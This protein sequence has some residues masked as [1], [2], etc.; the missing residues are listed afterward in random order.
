MLSAQIEQK[1]EKKGRNKLLRH[2]FDPLLL[3]CVIYRANAFSYITACRLRPINVGYIY[4]KYLESRITVM[5][6]IE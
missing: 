1:A 2:C 6:S 4:S 5:D 3:C